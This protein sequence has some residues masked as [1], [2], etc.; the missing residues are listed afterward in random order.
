MMVDLETLRDELAAIDGVQSCK[1]GVEAD[2]SPA[3]YPM[4]RLVPL[5]II[6]GR[7]YQN[8]EAEVL[9]YFG[10][11]VAHSEGM[12][13]VYDALFALE[14]A[15][16]RILRSSG[17]RYRETITDDAE[18]LRLP[19]QYKHMAIRCD[20]TTVTPLPPPAPPA[21]S[22]GPGPAPAPGPGPGPGPGPSPEPS[23]E[24]EPE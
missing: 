7:P 11:P 5:R 9:V 2:V 18:G 23:P 8:R 19:L 22:P 17:H 15:I 3:D 13:A 24:P 10:A 12:E 4:V 16:L 14:L 1:I 21:P 20:I 6:P